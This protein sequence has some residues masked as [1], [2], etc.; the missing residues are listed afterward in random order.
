MTCL[1]ILYDFRVPTYSAEYFSY[2]HNTSVRHILSHFKLFRTKKKV[3]SYII[4]FTFVVCIYSLDVKLKK[5]KLG[6]NFSTR[7]RSAAEAFYRFIIYSEF[8]I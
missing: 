5:A 4:A 2:I 8:H 6:A 7:Y 1:N 3:N